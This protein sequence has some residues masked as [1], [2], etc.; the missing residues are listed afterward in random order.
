MRTEDFIKYFDKIAHQY[1]K[2]KFSIPFNENR[3]HAFLKYVPDNGLILDYGCGPG[4]DAKYFFE[5]GYKPIGIDY[6]SQMVAE[7]RKWVPEVEFVHDDLLHRA[8]KKEYFDGIWARSIMHHIPLG[9]WNMYFRKIYKIL[10]PDGVFYLNAPVGDDVTRVVSQKLFKKN[11]QMI[12][13]TVRPSN[14]EQ[15]FKDNYFIVLEQG[16][17][18]KKGEQWVWYV[19]RKNG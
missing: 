1:A 7:A 9:K 15:L 8:I 16:E 4:R 5:H 12:H 10:K 19:L 2:E 13:S 14:L 11:V 17:Y 6:S 3:A 18:E